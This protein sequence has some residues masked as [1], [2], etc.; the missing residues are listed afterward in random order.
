[1]SFSLKQCVAGLVCDVPHR[2]R[3][4]PQMIVALVE[5]N[6][7]QTS[8]HVRTLLR[9]PLQHLRHQ[10]LHP[11]A[12]TVKGRREHERRLS[13]VLDRLVVVLRLE[14]RV[15]A[16]QPVEQDAGCPDVDALSVAT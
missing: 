16:D 11:T 15:P 6:V 12:V 9:I 1:M 10:L 14:G 2:A 4:R 7:L 8:T 3:M 13:D 5:P